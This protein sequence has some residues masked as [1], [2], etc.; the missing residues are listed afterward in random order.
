MRKLILMALLAFLAA[1]S[2]TGENAQG[3]VQQLEF[4]EGE[5]GCVRIQAQVDLNPVPLV[6]S[7]AQLTYVKRTS[8]AAPDC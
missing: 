4:E 6:S 3:L 8:E 5:E 7:N 2:S 1:C